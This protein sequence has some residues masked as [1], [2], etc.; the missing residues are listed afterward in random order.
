MGTGPLLPFT[1]NFTPKKKSYTS[2]CIIVYDINI[3][4]I[5]NS[6]IGALYAGTLQHKELPTELTIEKGKMRGSEEK[7]HNNRT[8]FWP[9]GWAGLQ[10]L[11]QTIRLSVFGLPSVANFS[12]TFCCPPP[13]FFLSLLPSKGVIIVAAISNNITIRGSSDG[14]LLQTYCRWTSYFH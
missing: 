8:G 2:D 1:R 6:V 11:S 7:I 5:V 13:C 12:I 4:F 9:K 3:V 10:M 14:S